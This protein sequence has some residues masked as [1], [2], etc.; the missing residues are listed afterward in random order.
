[1][2]TLIPN[3]DCNDF[4]FDHELRQQFFL[5]IRTVYIHAINDEKICLIGGSIKDKFQQHKITKLLLP[6]EFQNLARTT[7]DFYFRE[8][9]SSLPGDW[10]CQKLLNLEFVERLGKLLQNYFMEIC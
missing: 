5:E 2:T 7:I 8:N 9:N 10:D 3:Q 1:M 4:E 6:L